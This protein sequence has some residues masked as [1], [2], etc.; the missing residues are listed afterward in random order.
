MVYFQKLFWRWYFSRNCFQKRSKYEN[1]T[2]IDWPIE[3]Y[4]QLRGVPAHPPFDTATHGLRAA[5]HALSLARAA[6]GWRFT[7]GHG[8]VVVS[9]AAFGTRPGRAACERYAQHLRVARHMHYL[10]RLSQVSQDSTRNK[11]AA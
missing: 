6:T 5:R 1:F 4:V 7:R 3:G 8:L 9:A 2:I 11:A 10:K